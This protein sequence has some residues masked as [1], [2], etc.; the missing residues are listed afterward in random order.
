MAVVAFLDRHASNI[1]L[2]S[3]EHAHGIRGN[4][5]LERCALAEWTRWLFR[6]G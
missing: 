1:D 2:P 5:F 3:V 6:F 4:S